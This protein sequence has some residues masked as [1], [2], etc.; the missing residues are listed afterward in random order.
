MEEF[1]LDNYDVKKLRAGDVVEGEVVEVNDLTIYLDIHSFTEGTMHLDHYTKDKK[2]SSFKDLVKVGDIIKCEVAKV[3][4]EHIYLSRLNQLQEESFKKIA[5]A[6]ENNETITVYVQSDARGKGFNCKLDGNTLFMPISQSTDAVK[7]GSNVEVKVIDADLERRRLIVSRRVIEQEEYKNNK[8]AEYEAIN[9]GD[10]LTGKIVRIEKFGAIVRFN[11][12]QGLLKTKEV[13]HEFI[14]INEVLNV[15]DEI[16]VKVINKENGKLDLSR[17]ALL[18]SPFELF[19]EA[20]KVGETITGRV[21]N[22][23]PFGLL[24]EVAPNIKGLLHAS[25]YSHNPNDNFNNCVII[26]DEIEVAILKID[27]EHQKVSLSRKAL[28]DNP[29]A[30]VNAKVGDLVDVKVTEV[31]ENGLLVEALGVDG[32]VP[33]NEAIVD[34]KNDLSAYYAVGDTAKA[35][36]IEIDPRE[37]KL[38]LS[39]RKHLVEEERKSYEKYLGN[40][41]ESFSTNLGDILNK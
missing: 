29:W 7:I 16:E 11:Y 3:N 25:E 14:N 9:V 23:L 13:A 2:V 10:V 36:I 34:K 8:E 22:K 20:H 21:V 24:L 32:F 27:E 38:K 5:L 41:E 26:G 19:M 28:I 17:K 6:M 40:E 30:R 1:N 12:N 35:Y 33:A 39:I 37:W 31:K 18:K 15:G 4:E